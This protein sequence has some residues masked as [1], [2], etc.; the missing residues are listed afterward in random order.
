MLIHDK[1][2]N[3]PVELGSY[4]LEALPRDSSII[5]LETQRPARAS[6]PYVGSEKLLAQVSNNYSSYLGRFS[7]GE[8]ATRKAPVPNSLE[9]RSIDIKGATYFLDASHV[10]ICNITMN[11]WLTNVE[12]LEHSFAIVFLV[13]YGRLPEQ[14]NLAHEWLNGTEHDIARM[15]CVEIGSSL[16]GYIRKLG[17]NARSHFEGNTLVDL[18]RLAVLSG[19]AERTI[20]DSGNDLAI[21]SPF[22]EKNFALAV[23]STDYEL[24]IDTPFKTGARVSKF[25]YWRGINGAMSSREINR[26]NKRQSHLSRYP[27]EQIKRVERPSTLILDDEVPRVPKRAAFFA[28]ARKGDLGGKA[29]KE[30]TRFAVK[31]P[32]TAGMGPLFGILASKQEGDVAAQKSSDLNDPQAN[33]KALKSLAYHLGADLTGIC[34][35]PRYAWYSHHMDGEEIPTYH[36]YAVVMLIDQ[37]YGTMEGASGDDWISG[38][39]SMR[40]YLRGAEIAGVMS[41]FLRNKGYS[42]RPHTQ[43]DSD[44]LHIPL[45]LWAGLGE[46]SRIGELVLNPY[47]GPRFKSVVLTTDIPLEVDKPVDFGLQTFCENCLKC[48]R[49]CPVNAI[50]FKE[51]I[52]FNGYEIWKPDVERCTRYRVTNSKGSACGRCMKTCP[53]NKVVSADG[54]LLHRVGTWLGIHARWLKPLMVPIA[55][56]FDDWLKFGKRNLVKKWWLDLEIVDGVCVKPKATNERDI[57]VDRDITGEKSPVGYYS[58]NVMPAPNS[59][60]AVL[61]NHREAIKRAEELETVTE[62]L[63][64]HKNQGEKPKH[65]IPTKSL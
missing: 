14:D 58:A 33:A 28:R 18:D 6:L 55:V 29:Q 23:V 1:G 7:Q 20:D 22:V 16:S 34:E 41:E 19:I 57:D 24:A 4:P 63:V 35:I 59:T 62:A 46:L 32:L 26:R 21:Q 27:M 39:Q 40:G 61:A 10:G 51:K 65:Y 42:A 47:V 45:V 44:V 15:R 3:R 25:K 49:E 54:S 17:F 12:Q 8:A 64:R 56:F 9:R 52:M 48:A 13:A 11:S 43:A 36:R 38:G 5:E 50:P 53:L 30:V 31:H 2:H 60:E 37:G